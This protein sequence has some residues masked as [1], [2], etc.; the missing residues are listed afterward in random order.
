MPVH[1]EEMTAE[2]VPPPNAAS[3]TAASN[4]S[5]NAPDQ[6]DRRQRELLE[7]LQ[8]RAARLHAD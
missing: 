6:T 4:S 5:S 1:I 7:R 2:I 3:A 8:E